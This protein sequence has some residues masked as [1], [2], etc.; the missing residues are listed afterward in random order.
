LLVIVSVTLILTVKN[1]QT[2]IQPLLES[3]C[4]QTKQPNEIIIVD[5]GSSDSTVNIIETYQKKLPINLIV[6]PNVNIAQGRN[7]AIKNAKNDIIASTDGGCVLDKK[8]LEKIISPFEISK[9]TDVVSGAYLPLCEDKFQELAS[10]I[11]FPDVSKLDEN[12]LPSARS[13]AF[14]K[15][16]WEKVAGFPENLRTA[17]DTV[18]DMKLKKLGAR[19]VLSKD[20]IVFWRVRKNLSEVFKQFYNYAKGEG[21]ARFYPFNYLIRYGFFS[22][23]VLL[24]LFMPLN[25]FAWAFAIFSVILVLWLKRLRNVKN[26]RELPFCFLIAL[27]IELGISVGYIPGLFE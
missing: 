4:Q 19:F 23:L 7:I 1:E 5:G 20:A 11:I 26:L 17:E 6:L 27:S 14:K 3:I 16:L 8:W 25:P 22:G 15:A 2:T 9:E 18:F 10:Q 21:S 13:I 12:F 24:I